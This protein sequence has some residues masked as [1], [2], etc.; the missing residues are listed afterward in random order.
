M[1]RAVKGKL[2]LSEFKC[3]LVGEIWL[4]E[5]DKKDM[6][7]ASKVG[8]AWSGINVA[9]GTKQQTFLYGTDNG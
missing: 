8:H 2:N 9:V 6:N 7:P 4:E 1:E 5:E 3:K